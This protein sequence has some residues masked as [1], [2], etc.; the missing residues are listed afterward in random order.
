M[1]ILRVDLLFRKLESPQ[2]LKLLPASMD[3]STKKNILGVSGSRILVIVGLCFL[4]VSVASL[5][6]FFF[7]CYF[8]I[9]WVGGEDVMHFDS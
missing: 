6:C 7:I 2:V 4:I 5:R 9:F 1:E 8:F 3:D